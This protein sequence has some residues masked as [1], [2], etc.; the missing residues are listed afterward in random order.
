MGVHGYVLVYAITSRSSFDK[1]R[2]IN[3]VVMNTLGDPP[4]LP[5][6]LVGTM[7]DLSDARWVSCPDMILPV[8]LLMTLRLLEIFTGLSPKK[9]ARDWRLSLAYLF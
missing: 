5:R 3:E 4:E 6:I 8:A 7:A 1:I 9:M 2:T